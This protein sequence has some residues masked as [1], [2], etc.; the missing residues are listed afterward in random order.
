MALCC[1]D[2]CAAT[3]TP[4]EWC[5]DGTSEVCA[6]TDAPYRCLD[7]SY[8]NPVRHGPIGALTTAPIS[9]FSLPSSTS[10]IPTGIE[11]MDTSATVTLQPVTSAKSPPLPVGGVV[12]LAAAGLFVIVA[13]AVGARYLWKRSERRQSGCQPPVELDANH[14]PTPPQELRAAGSLQELH[15]VARIP[16]GAGIHE[17]GSGKADNEVVSYGA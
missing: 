16:E 13:A 11:P 4:T 3:N 1:N 14:G 9:T 10:A 8:A 15:G 6:F 5:C 7:Y 12:A 2:N 17:L